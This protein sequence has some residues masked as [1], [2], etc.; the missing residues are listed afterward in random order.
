M[1]ELDLHGVRHEDAKRLLEQSINH[2]WGSN[3]ELH[4][5]TGH[6]EKMKKIT[7]DILDEYKLGI[8]NR[9]FYWPK[10]GIY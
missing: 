2:L 1:T 6:S 7:V 4:I 5:I 3:E 10:Y 8:H 9:R